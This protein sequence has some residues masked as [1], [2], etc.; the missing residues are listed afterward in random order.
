VIEFVIGIACGIGLTMVVHELFLI[1][2]ASRERK[3][4]RRMAL[5]SRTVVFN[6]SLNERRWN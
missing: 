4:W 3:R 6:S 2:L 5:V 1:W